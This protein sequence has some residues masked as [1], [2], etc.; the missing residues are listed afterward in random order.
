[1]VF[2]G[3]GVFSARQQ[4]LVAIIVGV[5]AA[6]AAMAVFL[7]WLN[8]LIESRG[9]EDVDLSA[10]RAVRLA[11]LRLGGAL[12]TL[13]DLAARGIND[14]SG[15]QVAAL[16]R[17]AFF[18]P[19]VKEVAIVSG[20]G[21]MMCGSSGLI[22]ELRTIVMPARAGDADGVTIDVVRVGGRRSMVRVLREEGATSLAA[23]IPTSLFSTAGTQQ[24]IGRN[25][26][27]R[28]ATRDNMTIIEQGPPPTAGSDPFVATLRSELYGLTVVA[29]LPR[30]ALLPEANELKWQATM[31][32]AIM[33]VSIFLLALLLRRRRD[34][35]YSDFEQAIAANEFVPYYQ[36]IVD[37]RTGR[38]RGAEVL[39][40]WSKPDGSVLL[41]SAFI[42]FAESSGLIV[43]L[44]RV[45]M[46]RVRDEM[47]EAFGGRPELKLGFNLA[48]PHFA[49]DR[50]VADVREI[51]TDGPI[52]L[53]QI[54]FEV[55]ERQP[56]QN[57]AGARR[58]IA[59]L[60]ELGCGVAID[61]VGTG[62]GGLSYI[63]KLGADVIKIDKLFIDAIGSEHHSTTILET[64]VDLARSMRMGVVAEGV[65]NFEQVLKLRELGILAAQGY[66]FSP[67]LP[68]AS[69]LQLL[70]ALA[71]M[72][73]IDGALGRHAV[74]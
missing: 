73:R 14:C 49:D 46:R 36:P 42:P 40:R 34:D 28:V 58:I 20:D 2:D 52:P 43:P 13:D 44:T 8:G 19:A 66:V 53:R 33:L 56:L 59:G 72:P 11:D 39:L 68:G 10:Q 70:E 48:A 16:Q 71:P 15:S 62:H 50:I 57:L 74:A 18:N 29:S 37:I 69:F 61:D 17:A 7:L 26:Y 41:P 54:M 63:L 27:V 21:R 22:P 55:T 38:L 47:G 12:A 30:S 31:F 51:F 4:R 1:L 5:V 9:R 6:A 67:P 25:T 24:A 3:V 45:L 65:E 35:P 32:G 23:L 64:L 60:Q